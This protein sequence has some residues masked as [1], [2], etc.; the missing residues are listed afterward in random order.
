MNEEGF[1]L[2]FDEMGD[3]EY[4]SEGLRGGGRSKEGVDQRVDHNG[5]KV[6]C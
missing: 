2:A 3:D 1:E 4:E 6:F 5:P